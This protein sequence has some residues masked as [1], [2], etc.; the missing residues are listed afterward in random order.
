M[1][2]VELDDVCV[3]VDVEVVE[4]VVVV[5]SVVLVELVIVVVLVAPV[6]LVELVVIVVLIEV[7]EV[8]WLGTGSVYANQ[9]P[10]MPWPLVSPGALSPL[11][12]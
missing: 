8:S 7:V 5:E 2:Q 6:P 9:I 12:W 4:V 10:P 3:V 1:V 11:K